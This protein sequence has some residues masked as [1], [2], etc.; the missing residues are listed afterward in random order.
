MKIFGNNTTVACRQSRNYVLCCCKVHRLHGWALVPTWKFYKQKKI[1]KI[2]LRFYFKVKIFRNFEGSLKNEYMN[3]KLFPSSFQPYIHF[4]FLVHSPIRSFDYNW[5]NEFQEGASNYAHLS[6][7][8]LLVSE[9]TKKIKQAHIRKEEEKSFL[10]VYWTFNL[11]SP[12]QDISGFKFIVLFRTF[13]KFDFHAENCKFLN[14][15]LIH[16]RNLEIM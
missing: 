7:S 3:G 2:N 12:W 14:F 8:T 16:S 9:V 1:E 13:K 6:I 15:R 11:L 4:I 10:T 5:W